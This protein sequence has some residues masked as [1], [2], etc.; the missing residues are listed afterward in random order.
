MPDM[1][2]FKVPEGE[3]FFAFMVWVA[4]AGAALILLIDY[5]MKR[6]LLETMSHVHKD[7]WQVRDGKGNCALDEQ[8]SEGRSKGAGNPARTVASPVLGS[9]PANGDATVETANAVEHGPFPVRE[10]SQQPRKSNGRFS[11]K[12]SDGIPGTG[13]PTIPGTNHPVV[14]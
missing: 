11:G 4:L 10:S 2:A 3:K 13:N 12:N 5:Q 7:L 6:Q 14:P 9:V 8:G 1:S